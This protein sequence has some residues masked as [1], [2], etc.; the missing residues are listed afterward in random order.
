MLKHNIL[1]HCQFGLESQVTKFKSK[2]FSICMEHWFLKNPLGGN[3]IISEASIYLMC[4]WETL[5]NILKNLKKFYSSPNWNP[6]CH[7][8]PYISSMYFSS[9]N[10]IYLSCQNPAYSSERPS[11]Q[12]NKIRCYFAH[13]FSTL[14]NLHHPSTPGSVSVSFNYDCKTNIPLVVDKTA[15]FA[16]QFHKLL[17]T[18]TLKI[19]CM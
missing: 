3:I 9:T 2:R 14:P 7:S 5:V 13:A 10:N 18:M 1:L 11:E 4:H 16:C 6:D 12:Y 19:S 17:Q 8:S 15:L